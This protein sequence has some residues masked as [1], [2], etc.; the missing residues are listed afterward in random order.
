ML[1]SSLSHRAASRR[2]FTDITDVESLLSFKAQ[3]DDPYGMLATNWTTNTS[4]CSWVGVSCG[5]RHQRV[6]SIK[7]RDFRLQ[8]SVSPHLGNLSFL[9]ELDLA[10]CSLR[11]PIPPSL[12]RLPRLKRLILQDNFLS[13]PIPT[14]IFNMSSLVLLSLVY[15]NLTGT[16]P[17][18]NSF[19]VLPRLEFLSLSANQ[20]TG[21]IPSAFAESRSLETFS[22]SYNGFTGT[23]PAE[24]GHLSNLNVLF[25][26]KNQLTGR[27]PNSLGN[28]TKLT[29]LEL[30]FNGFE[31][32]IPKDL[33]NLVNLEEISLSLNQLTG[34]IP[35][36]L[37][38]CKGLQILSLTSNQLIGAIPDKLGNLSE[39]RQLYL[40]NNSLTGTIPSSFG[41]LT[42][43][44]TIELAFNKI[45]GVIPGELGYLPNIENLSLGP[46][47]LSG[48][49]PNSLMN[50]STLTFLQ[51]TSSNLT[52]EI[53]VTIGKSLPLL[54]RLF[55][56]QNQF[57]GGLDFITSLSNCRNLVYLDISRNA[58]EGVVPNSIGNLSVDLIY[59]SAALNNIGGE[60]PATLCNLSSL[61]LLDLST[62]ELVATIPQD[63]AKL[64]K[65][66]LLYLGGNKISG[67]LPSSL[68]SMRGLGALYLDENKLIGPIPDSIGNITQLQHL[69]LSSNQ[70]SSTIPMSLWNI[71]NLIELNLSRNSLHGLLPPQVGNLKALDVL[72]LSVN[73][74][75]GN[76]SN[77]L[78]QL[79]MLT[80]LDLSGNSF[81]GEIPQS[82]G[83]LIN[84]KYLNLSHNFLSGSIYKS[85]GD[86]PLL[87][88]LDL[89][90]N[91]LEGQ[92]PKGRVFAN[93]SIPS[94]EG[95]IALCGA[96]QLDFPPCNTNV[97]TSSSRRKLHILKYILPVVALIVIVP[98]SLC[99]VLV[100][101]R[102]RMVKENVAHTEFQG[103]DDHRLVSYHELVH[104]TD[105]FNQ[106]NLVGKGSFGSVY[107]G[108]LDD[109]L[110]IAVKVLNLD[111][112]GASNS[113]ESECKALS[114][115]RH[116]N[117][118][119]IISI[120]SKPNFKALILQ[121]M[122]KGNLDQWL[123]S[124]AHLGL[125]QRLNIVVDVSLAL[126]Y[127]H[128]RHPHTVLHCDLK[129]SN[130][131]L[132]EE[133]TAHV[134]DFG[135]A[136]LLFGDKSIVSASTPGTMGY[137]APE[138]GST[139]T[140]SKFGD[141]YSFGILLLEMI[142]RKK[143]TDAMFSGESSM[144]AWILEAYSA[145][146]LNVVDHDLL[147]EGPNAAHKAE[148][149]SATN[150]CLSSIIELGLICSSASPME[151]L[152]MTL[153][154]PRLQKIR[155]EYMSQLPVPETST[156][157][158][159]EA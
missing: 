82:L 131:L 108:C 17:S 24:F 114:T 49:L 50:A 43:A 21:E 54:T 129:P 89:S 69:S 153:V 106:A 39:L 141:V 52:G 92:I 100:L 126:E 61:L 98:A 15:N 60:I 144:R 133:M 110:I 5:S 97:E 29:I 128:H 73:K 155:K 51:V 68:N 86:L 74:L 118:I 75:S 77:A 65:L 31:G 20:L 71:R 111:V 3:I 87:G 94:L 146:L 36:S 28:L 124:D 44:I 70:L 67:L 149:L 158:A 10:N 25:L 136:K 33:G 7:L 84:V 103:L 140:V 134:S 53:P 27:I 139:G 23:I 46:N 64:D 18:N 157:L 96:P 2:T 107:R 142:T 83:S 95:N 63:I 145:S 112:K 80:R 30:S 34:E 88:N 58:F 79:V 147:E 154:A 66:Q 47:R 102:R 12:A 151:R 62:N 121:F 55:I 159:C 4:F 101:C 48:T 148:G 57:T 76:I 11:G 72:D 26:G 38:Q 150:Q 127:L 113:F 1:T 41:N 93:H 138:Y 85:I 122:P 104:A 123:Y 19:V 109:G 35:S 37:A 117:L 137:I 8:G 105:N 143:P 120:C 99:L 115:I 135:I 156:A 14:S 42:N 78:G 81:Q 125:L 152:P 116:R 119:K 59:F 132:D 90:F 22:L 6:T 13:G 45:K 32:E 9:S 91:K 130:V 40:G 16:L 56:N